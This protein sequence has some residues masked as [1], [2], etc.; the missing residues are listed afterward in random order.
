MRDNVDNPWVTDYAMHSPAER[1][2]EF[3]TRWDCKKN[4]PGDWHQSQ[5]TSLQMDD[6][7]CPTKTASFFFKYEK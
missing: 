7:V 4:N 1:M 5:G 2:N 6:L 3:T